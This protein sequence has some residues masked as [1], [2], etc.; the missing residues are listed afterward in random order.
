MNNIV[1]DD[2]HNYR[3]LMNKQHKKEPYIFTITT[4]NQAGNSLSSSPTSDILP[5]ILPTIQTFTATSSTTDYNNI[6]IT[7]KIDNGGSDISFLTLTT[8]E[9]NVIPLKILTTSLSTSATGTPGNIYGYSN[10]VVTKD[11]TI[12]TISTIS[13]KINSF[14]LNTALNLTLTAISSVGTSTL[15]QSTTVTS[16]SL[17]DPPSNVQV[18]RGDKQCVISFTPP[19]N[20][21]GSVLSYKITSSSTS[22][23]INVSGTS[24]PITITGLTN[25]TSYVFNIVSTNLSGDSSPVTTSPVTPAGLP[26]KSGSNYAL[27]ATNT[28]ANQSTIS[29]TGTIDPNGSPIKSYG[30]VVLDSNL[31]EIPS[32]TKTGVPTLPITITG[33]ENG[34]QY[35]FVL[36]ATNDVGTTSV[37]DIP[38]GRVTIITP[39]IPKQITDLTVVSINNG[40]QL[41]FTPPIPDSNETITG[42]TLNAYYTNTDGST[43]KEIINVPL[44]SIKG[45]TDGKVQVTLNT[46]NRK[47]YTGTLTSSQLDAVT[48]ISSDKNTLTIKQGYDRVPLKN[49]P[50][51]N[52]RKNQICFN[53]V[54]FYM[55]LIL[56]IFIVIGIFRKC[57]YR[58]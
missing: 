48:A 7:A 43:V 58:R 2:Y 20:T 3:D 36:T 32:L 22:S 11:P 12:S 42:Y 16:Y 45:L 25:G 55:C 15:P 13:F 46:S 21:G 23:L 38:L 24:S 53:S 8:N 26:I 44:N 9:A 17:P 39:N 37:S 18:T 47:V 14:K 19:I 30:V 41:T 54:C 50:I 4:T 6:N 35:S 52:E 34:T 56:F 51:G 28:D 57:F 31:I 49:Y 29:I 1:Y 5:L 40:I 10:L 33:L 27:N